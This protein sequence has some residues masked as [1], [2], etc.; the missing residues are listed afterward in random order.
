[1]VSTL[2]LRPSKDHKYRYLWNFFH[3]NTGYAVILLSFFNTWL[4]F[5]ILKPAKEWMIT[6]G[7]VFGALILS[8]FLLEVW[9]KFARDKTGGAYEE[10]HKLASTSPVNN[11]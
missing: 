11:L 6:Y 5:S 7:V 8:T 4:A 2:L 3:H 10:V 9:K 1:M